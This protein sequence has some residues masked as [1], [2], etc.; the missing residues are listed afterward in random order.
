MGLL[1][2]KSSAGSGKTHTLVKDY[3]KITLRAPETKFRH[4]LAITFTNKAAGEMKERIIDSLK[5]FAAGDTDNYLANSIKEELSIDNETL[6][7]RASVLLG[8]IIHHYDDFNIS[9]IDSFVHKIIRT[10]SKEVDL[11][12]DFEVVLE[13]D[14]IIPDI[15]E[16]IYDR[17]TP[18]AKDT[19]T[20]F[21]INFVNALTDDEKGYDPQKHLVDFIKKQTE[22]GNF[23]EVNKLSDLTL[24]NFIEI[25]GRLKEKLKVIEKRIKEAS[26]KSEDLLIQHHLTEKHFYRRKANI[27]T[28]LT[29][30]TQKINLQDLFPGKTVLDSINDDKWTAGKISTE[31]ESAIELIKEQ[32]TRYF[33]IIYGAAK[34]YYFLKHVHD[35]LYKVALVKEISDLFKE[36]SLV[37]GKVHISEFNKR[38][39]Q[40]VAGQPVPFIYERLGTKF[41]HFLIDEFQ[42]T[43]IMQWYNIFPLIENAYSSSDPLTE[44]SFFNMLVGDPKQAIYRFRG[45]EVELFTSLPKFYGDIEME[46]KQ[47]REH[48]LETMLHEENLNTNFRSYKN[49]VDFNNRFFEFIRSQNDGLIADIYQNHEQN[50]FSKKENGGYVS[51]ELIDSENARDYEEKRLEKIERYIDELKEN[52]FEYSDICILTRS[53]KHGA[54]IASYLLK[55]NI[56]VIS[57]ESLL[58]ANAPEVRFTIAVFKVMLQPDNMEAKTELIHNFLLIKEKTEEL[59]NTLHHLVKKNL[60]EILNELEI[61]L[62]PDTLTQKTILEATQIIFESIGGEKQSNIYFQYFMDFII[63]KE[64]IIN[65][66]IGQFLDLWEEK[67]DNLFIV[68]PEGQDAVQIMTIHKS[69]GLKF[70]VVILDDIERKSD[71]AKREQWINPQIDDIPELKTTLIPLKKEKEEIIYKSINLSTLYNKE[72]EKTELDKINLMY[73]AFTRPVE[74]LFILAENAKFNKEGELSN[75]EYFSKTINR[76]LRWKKNSKTPE[77]SNKI[78]FGTLKKL[79]KAEIAP[80]KYISA[81]KKLGKAGEYPV[82]VAPVENIYWENKPRESAAAKG[83]LIHALLSNIRTVEDITKTLNNYLNQGLIDHQEYDSLQ[84]E[85]KKVITHPELIEYFTSDVIIKTETELITA[86]GEIIRPDR[87]IISKDKITVLDYK[88][89]SEKPEHIQQVK[90]YM[91]EIQRIHHTNVTGKLIY[92]G[93]DITVKN[94]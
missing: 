5:M 66:D 78:E 73:V 14:D 39:S 48:L 7:K 9:T 25:I 44:E 94:V 50:V 43:S 90:N 85:L 79:E 26:R 13:I 88:T 23:Y 10:F 76:F 72:K 22:E 17:L 84:N 28:Y 93:N 40:T 24:E 91:H 80:K 57:S 63:E 42:D 58:I 41:E 61:D 36:Y 77:K 52:G 19:F 51:I 83:K 46:N 1:A 30:F 75:N 45:G 71:N 3:L 68:I 2:Y 55:K 64:N 65:N 92:L 11:P 27:A 4:V 82:S 49:I 74:A 54:E 16:S 62:Q 18:E 67:K 38:I 29:K 21:M 81:N 6:Q 37:S 70:Q 56:P 32:L 8:K 12:S 87:V 15:I 35:N 60:P 31:E 33:Q 47:Q 53:T 86:D 69:K 59:N 89:G 20:R 34:E